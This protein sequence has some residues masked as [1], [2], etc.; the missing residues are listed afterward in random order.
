MQYIIPNHVS[1]E[2][3]FNQLLLKRN[4]LVQKCEHIEA[5]Y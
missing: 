4:K 1:Y 5:T 2:Y 3:L